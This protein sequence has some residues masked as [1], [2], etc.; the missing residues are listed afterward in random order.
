MVGVKARPLSLAGI[1]YTGN[2]D[3]V[4]AM[5][6]VTAAKKAEEKI[7][8]SEKPEARQLLDLS[9]LHITELGP[10]GG[11]LLYTNQAS[12]DYFTALLWAN[13]TGR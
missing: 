4:G 12:L 10:G 13:G 5:T 9:P 1:V 11:T 7:R 3:F 2:L 8:Q 6:D